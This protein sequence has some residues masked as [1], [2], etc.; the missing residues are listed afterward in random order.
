MNTP[1]TS[2]DELSLRRLQW[3]VRGALA[4]GVAASV[5]ANVLHAE[6]SAVGRAIAAWPPL[7]LLLTIEL[8]SRVP[9]H[10]PWLSGLRMGT[11]ALVA[12]IAAWVSY[13][14]MVS[15]AARYGEASTSAHLIP[16][17]VDGL[18]VVASGCLVEIGGRRR[19]VPAP[20]ADDIASPEAVEA[21]EAAETVETVDKTAKS[22]IGR[23]TPRPSAASTVA[24]LRAKHP[25][26]TTGQ[27]AR[28]AGVSERTVRRHLNLSPG[29]PAELTDDAGRAAA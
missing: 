7:A 12:G 8:I 2:Y 21:V 6:P 14:H 20:V 19:D 4:L 22:T 23:R 17:S 26:W 29:M 15:V 18:V 25:D 27:I 5:T 13:W 28:R 9:V 11:T 3:A 16:L 1:D 10:R 24:R